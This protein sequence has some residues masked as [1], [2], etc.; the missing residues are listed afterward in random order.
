MWGGVGCSP[1]QGD[2]C[3]GVDAGK[4]GSD[5]EEVVKLA[6]EQPIV[7]FVVDGVSEVHHCVEGRHGGFSKSQVHQEVIGDG[8]HPLVS[9]D[10]PHHHHVPHHRHHD[11]EGVGNGPQ[12]H[13]PQGLD[14]LVGR[15]LVQGGIEQPSVLQL[16]FQRR[17][18]IHHSVALPD[19]A[20]GCFGAQS[21]LG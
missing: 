8:A 12:G 21:P 2:G 4:D 1:V 10:D 11:D 3:H 17:G 5:G 9:Q 14:E 13:L 7:P 18:V 20:G 19:P 15:G 6:V 16:C